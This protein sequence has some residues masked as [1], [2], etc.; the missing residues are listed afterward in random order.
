MSARLCVRAFARLCI[1]GCVRVHALKCTHACHAYLRAHLSTLPCRL[2][3][4]IG[5]FPFLMLSSL[6]LFVDPHDVRRC[7]NCML[8]TLRQTVGPMF[9]DQDEQPQDL[10]GTVEAAYV[11]CEI[12]GLPVTIGHQ[13]GKA[14]QLHQRRRMSAV[15]AALFTFFLFHAVVPLRSMLYPGN[16]LWDDD[17]HIF[18]WYAIHTRACVCTCACTHVQCRHMM[19]RHR[20]GHVYLEAQV[21]LEN[22]SFSC[23]NFS[24]FPPL[25]KTGQG[26]ENT[27]G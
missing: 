24:Q 13:E 7:A 3:F 14:V 11:P 4:G 23:L 22:S 2:V 10:S 18:S 25:T 12:G 27:G 21:N 15:S 6:I 19:L 16:S 1:R 20:R 9:A 17:G 8:S 26:C 5:S